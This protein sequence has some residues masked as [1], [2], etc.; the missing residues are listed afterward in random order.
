M[1]ELSSDELTAVNGGAKGFVAGDSIALDLAQALHWDHNARI[2]AGS[3]EIIKKVPEAAG[4]YFMVISAGS[5]DPSNPNLGANLEAMRRRAGGGVLWIAPVDPHAR[6]TVQRVAD[7]HG[8]NVLT[9]TPG[10]DGVHPR[11]Y[12]DMVRAVRRY[13]GE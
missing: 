10:R 8:D 13:A 3:H 5:N 1:K 11:A 12:G 9:F 4:A 6:E 7:S 2:G